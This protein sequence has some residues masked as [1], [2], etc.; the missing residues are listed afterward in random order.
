MKY[1]ILLTG[2]N[3]AVIDDFFSLLNDNI[4]WMTTSERYEDILAH[5][6]YFQPDAVC[7]CVR[8]EPLTV[9]NHITALKYRLE[10]AHI[11]LILIGTEENCRD[12][13]RAMYRVADLVLTTPLSAADL[14]R[15]IIR[16]LEDLEKAKAEA[17]RAEE[18]EPADAQ[19]AEKAVNEMEATP[20]RKLHGTNRIPR[21]REH[22]RKIC[23]TSWW[24]TTA[25]QC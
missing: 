18:N 11:A 9:A 5:L 19:K 7:F 3:F 10:R 12:F 23:G 1:K 25:P 15:A 6:K 14:E 17:Q 24:L 4:E 8:N 13:G 2:K 21:R 20:P 22:R 16:Y